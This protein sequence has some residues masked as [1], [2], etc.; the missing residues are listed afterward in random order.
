MSSD[1]SAFPDPVY[2][3]TVLAVNFQDAQKH[4]LEPLL[5]I[6]YA[7][8]LMLARQK[9][10][11][12][13]AA[14]QCIE[15]LD[16]LDRQA[17]ATA[18]YDGRTED[19]FFFVEQALEAACGPDNAGR[20]HTARSRNDIDI[21]Q[22]R[23]L[24]RERI[25]QIVAAL[26]KARLTL[27]ALAH[28]HRATLMPAYTHTQ[29][30]QP[31]TFGHYL[32]GVLELLER[33]ANR[34]AAAYTTV[35]RCPLGACAISTTGFPID[36]EFTADL[37]GF[38]GLQLNSYGAIAATDYVTETM[39]T[40]ATAMVNLGRV[41]QDLLQWSTVEFGYLRLTDAWVQISSIMPQKR[42][43]V[44]LEHVR[45]LASKALAEATGAVTMLHN[46]PFADTNDAEDGLQPLVLAAAADAVRVLRIFNGVMDTCQV[47][48]ARM[49]ERAASDFLTVTELADTLV[50]TEG[51]S[52]RAAH[53]LVS[54]AVKNLAGT[55]SI[56]A[57]VDAVIRLAPQVIGRP[58]HTDRTLQE[59]ALDP[60]NFIAV[61]TVPGGP[62][63]QPMETAL[64]AAKE[65]LTRSAVWEN[66]RLE[67]MQSYPK[68]IMEAAA[69]LSATS[70]RRS[71]EDA[72][73]QKPT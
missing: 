60:Q 23:M 22:Y 11:P 6:H 72:A 20:M 28:K 51:F 38:D 40:I 7:H 59:K 3:E 50:R 15:A 25:L 65:A 31:I 41:T 66:A 55:Y 9:I 44:P 48:E 39:G 21:T 27:L 10:I 29:P 58:L 34:F 26:N 61:R 13:A 42:N 8:T 35:N 62:A 14:K 17:L 64:T 18:P 30:A 71:D 68:R 67:A 12:A 57:M 46:T 53:H 37:L 2:A 4:F 73:F 45:L 47:N 32:L 52:F 24:L 19:L 56:G 1:T 43:P 33:D 54:A 36:R 63:P 69:A 5:Q 70:L 16:G 49:A